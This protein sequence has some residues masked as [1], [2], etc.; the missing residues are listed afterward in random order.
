MVSFSYSFMTRRIT[1]LFSNK[2]IYFNSIRLKCLRSLVQVVNSIICKKN[3]LKISGG[4][5]LFFSRRKESRSQFSKF[6]F[7]FKRIGKI[8]LFS[9]QKDFA[10]FLNICEIFHSIRV[11]LHS[12]RS[13]NNDLAKLES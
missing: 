11:T 12:R 7:L 10:T 3:Y 8:F 1:I 9:F 5:S 4:K 6:F 13:F 2:R